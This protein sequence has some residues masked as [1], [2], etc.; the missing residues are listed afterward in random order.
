VRFGWSRAPLWVEVAGGCVTAV[1]LILL[2]VVFRTN[3]F[4]S[5][6]VRVQV[7]RG[8]RVIDSGPY[9]VVRHP[10]YAAGSLVVLGGSLLL[11]S[12]VGAGVAVLMTLMLAVRCL[13]EERTLAAGLEGYARYKEWVRYRMVPGIW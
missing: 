12:Y 7:E 10:M 13:F 8:Q 5:Y 3:T 11:G 9:S 2:F 1:G 6:V 4:L